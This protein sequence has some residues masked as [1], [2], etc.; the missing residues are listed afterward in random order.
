M[1]RL[2]RVIGGGA[3][4][5]A[6]MFMSG[7]MQMGMAMQP[8]QA[9]MLRAKQMTVCNLPMADTKITVNKMNSKI[10]MG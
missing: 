7:A 6:I 1:K 9:K 3:V 5:V 8:M 2:N 4:A 10:H